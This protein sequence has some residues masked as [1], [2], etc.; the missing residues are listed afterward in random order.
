MMRWIVGSS[1]RARKGVVATAAV[2]LAVGVWQLR[3][4][5]VDAL[6]E[7]GPTVVEV[8]TEALGLSAEEMEQLITTPLEQDLLNGVAWMESI[9]SQSVPGLSN[10]VME[11]EPG[12]DLY[13]A[14]QVVQERLNEAHALP[15][16]AKVPAMLQPQSSTSRVMMIRL[17][18]EE[19]TPIELGV[20]ARWT[21]VPRLSGA[22][23]VSNVVIWGQKERQLQ[24]L[25][26]PQRLAGAGVTL[27]EVVR[28]TG[29]SLWASPL[30]FLEAS[31]PGT[32]GFI[33]QNNQRLGVQH[34]SPI[35][36]AADLARVVI[37]RSDSVDGASPALRLGD[38]AEVVEDHQPLIGDAVVSGGEGLILVVEKLPGTSTSEV[39][40]AVEKALDA[41]RP[42]LD[43]VDIDTGIYRPATY[44]EHASDNL[45]RAAIIGSVLAL[46]GLVAFLFSWR[47]VLISAVA[48][49]VSLVA[50]ALVLHLRDS[51]L[52][53]IVIAAL[54]MALAAVVDDAVVSVDSAV[55]RLR[56]A[57]G[58]RDAGG[59]G[60]PGGELPDSA[61]VAPLIGQAAL[62]VS[63]SLGFALAVMVVALV[64]VFVLEGLAGESFYPPLAIS[65]LIA[66][67]VSFLVAVT[68]TPAL[69]LLLLPKSAALQSEPPLVRSLQGLYRRALRPTSRGVIPAALIGVVA[70][71]LGALAYTQ[72]DRSLVPALEETD[73]L[74]RWN[75][76][77][78]TSLPEM[79]RITAR[80]AE[81]LR[82]LRGVRDVD[83]HVGR[84]VRGDLVGGANQG[85]IWISL[86]QDAG[87]DR[88]VASIEEVVNGYPGLE[89]KVV[90]YSQNRISDVL[91]TE[92]TPIRVRVYGQ[93]FEVLKEKA[94]EVG[95]LL[96]GIDGAEE[97]RVQQI[98]TEPTIEIEVD[99]AKAQAAGIKPGDVR[100]AATTLVSGIQVGAL[101]EAQKIFE[102]Q[103][104]GV[105]EVRRNASDIRALL[106]DVPGGGHVTL[107]DVADV[108]IG[109][110]P[111]SIEHDATSRSLD[112]TA[113]VAGRSRSDVV[114][115]LEAQLREIGFPLEYHAEVLGDYTD[116]TGAERKVAFFALGA[117]LGIFLLLQA[118]FSSWRLAL[119]AFVSLVAAVS[120]GFIAAWLDS[121][122]MTLA[123]V[124]GVLAVLAVATRQLVLLIG[125]YQHLEHL[126][127]GGDRPAVVEV[128]SVDGL[129]AVVTSVGVTALALLPTVVAGTMAGQEI[130]KPMAVVVIGGLVTTSVVTLFVLPA[131]YLQVPPPGPAEQHG[132]VGRAA[133]AE[134]E[135]TTSVAPEPVAS[136]RRVASWPTPPSPTPA[137]G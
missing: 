27:D 30:T 78:G 50:A 119:L 125:R 41:M 12:T 11:F 55:R 100:R 126:A 112:V 92:Q 134:A 47:R 63:R 9:R 15:N 62:E 59:T 118:A 131:L 127:G 120:G 4:A 97:V 37:D 24:V 132:V 77:P 85:E 121:G 57:G 14:R 90:T 79:D 40:S 5:H 109:S 76:P 106:L 10:I 113:A 7:F 2:I 16:V 93:D 48:I 72:L 32:G 35:K 98:V 13:R 44:L 75:G 51:T 69:S 46:F 124:A 135:R 33:D 20:L 84:A 3:D 95:R 71:V 54:V 34:L 86:D 122:A 67:V 130:V 42:G 88:T 45:T 60:T 68:V 102:V 64:P 116:R 56:T 117:A 29:N 53:A 28:T 74:V 21:I 39:T 133:G 65:F 104:W 49:A 123:T 58:I 80:A 99:L 136:M 115:D 8:Q 137:E 25:V 82:A 105:P 66:V 22:P 111:S 83:A 19:L 129:G 96:S 107:G 26:D 17:S 89:R 6:P 23:G 52:N 61:P 128:G 87:Y 31:T 114:V 36:T 73:L 103:V 43:G 18:S 38:V 1:L 108:R 81:E 110:S 94:G 91:A 70:I 101:F